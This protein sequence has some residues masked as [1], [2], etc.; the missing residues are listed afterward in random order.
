MFDE[1]GACQSSESFANP[2]FAARAAGFAGNEARC[3]PEEKEGGHGR[4]RGKEE[5]EAKSGGRRRSGE[6]KKAEG[7][8]TTPL[9]HKASA[10]ISAFA[11][12]HLVCRLMQF[13]VSFS[14]ILMLL[15][16]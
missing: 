4:R 14:S 16:F 1:F 10:G 8:V 2:R 5:E 12:F 13:F 11:R 9:M 6:E 3:V 15:L 7:G